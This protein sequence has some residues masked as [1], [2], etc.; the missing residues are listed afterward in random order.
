[1]VRPPRFEP[2]SPAWEASVLTKLDYGRTCELIQQTNKNKAFPHHTARNLS[3]YTLQK[4]EIRLRITISHWRGSEMVRRSAT[5]NLELASEKLVETLI[6][7]LTPET[8]R[9]TTS[10]SRVRLEGK[11]KR[12]TIRIEANDTSALRATLN[13]YLRWVALVRNT[14]KAAANLKKTRP[15]KTLN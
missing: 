3:N 10:R 7:A 5:I 2:G 8:R 13:S 14:Y 11:G 6:I 9:P 4:T 15:A 1:M 12:L